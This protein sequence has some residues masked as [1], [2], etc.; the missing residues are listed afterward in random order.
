L[1]DTLSQILWNISS[2]DKVS[3]KLVF[4]GWNVAS[5]GEVIGRT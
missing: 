5:E 3:E 4:Y 1:V 2:S